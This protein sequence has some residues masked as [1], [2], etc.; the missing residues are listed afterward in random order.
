[1][2]YSFLPVDSWLQPVMFPWTDP[3]FMYIWFNFYY[4]FTT[5]FTYLHYICVHIYTPTLAAILI[6]S[7]SD[8]LL[9]RLRYVWYA[10]TL[11][12]NPLLVWLCQPA[13]ALTLITMTVSSPPMISVT[14]CSAWAWVCLESL[15]TFFNSYRCSNS[16]VLWLHGNT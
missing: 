11:T 7:S 1:M 5:L 6:L 15:P 3:L 2:F 14:G 8:P 12:L 16:S 4:L 9:G 10:M 13:V